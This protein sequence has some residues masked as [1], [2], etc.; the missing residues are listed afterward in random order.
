MC[1][2][3]LFDICGITHIESFVC[4]LKNIGIILHMHVNDDG[5]YVNVSTYTPLSM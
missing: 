2:K 4:A 1:N 3:S 5:D